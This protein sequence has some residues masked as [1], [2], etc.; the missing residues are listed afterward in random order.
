ML[1][2]KKR[3]EWK[4]IL[5]DGLMIRAIKEKRKDVTRRLHGV[6]NIDYYGSANWIHVSWKDKHGSQYAHG[7]DKIDIINGFCPYHVGQKPW[8]KE[9]FL[10]GEN[11]NSYIYRADCY[12]WSPVKWKPSLFMPRKASRIDLLVT[13]I[14]FGQLGEMK[15]EDFLRE[16]FGNKE[17]FVELWNRKNP[18]DKYNDYRFVWDI[19]FDVLEIR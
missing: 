8:V 7:V 12:S 6:P 17:E 15:Q 13:K 2:M 18:K 14:G 11:D 16:G 10:Y 19:G 4:P 9:T 1:I 5:F 3:S